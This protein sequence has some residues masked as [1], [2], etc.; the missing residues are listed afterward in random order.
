MPRVSDRVPTRGRMFLCK[1]EPKTAKTTAMASFPGE[2]YII[3]CDNRIGWLG[4][5]PWI[6]AKNIEYDS[7]TE[8]NQVSKKLEQLENHNDFQNIILSSIT[9]LSRATINTLFRNRGD[10]SQNTYRKKE[11]SKDEQSTIGGIPI[12]GIAEYNGESSGLNQILTQLRVIHNV[13][14]CNVF[15][16]AHI[17]QGSTP[18]LDGSVREFRRIVTGGNKVA[19][20]LPVYFDE[21]YHFYCITEPDSTRRAYICH[22]RNNSQDF[23]GTAIPDLPDTINHTNE[24]F[25]KIWSSYLPKVEPQKQESPEMLGLPDINA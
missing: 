20:E 19:A 17:V 6:N 2:T 9:S 13:W 23:A 18:Q 15:V 4:D 7:Y 24:N 21:I 5:C 16:E 1:G 14:K 3:D 11:K 8:W 22:T 10:A 12:M 25:Y